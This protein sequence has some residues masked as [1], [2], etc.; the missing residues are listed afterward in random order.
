VHIQKLTFTALFIAIG[1]LSAHLVYIP[2]VVAKCFPVQH[3]INI[4]ISVFLGTRY[5]VSAAFGISL[6]RNVLGTGSLLAFPGSMIGAALSGMVY[7]RTNSLFGAILGEVVG[8]GLIGGLFAYPVAKYLLGTE[9]GIFFFVIPFLVSTIGGSL[10]AYLIYLTPIKS[11]VQ[12]K[13]NARRN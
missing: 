10:I 1:V 11:F 9:V 8:T 5:S 13:F 7:H 4:L 12:T 2:V 3:A 6:L